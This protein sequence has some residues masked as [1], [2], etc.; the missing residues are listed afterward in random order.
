MNSN[1]H[2]YKQKLIA[3]TPLLLTSLVCVFFIV[4][5]HQLTK[6]KITENRQRAALT[7]INDVMPANYDNDIFNDNIKIDVPTYINNTN[8]I[9]AYRARLNNQ[10]VAVSLMPVMTKGY[11]GSISL[12]I[13]IAYDGTLNGVRIISHHETEGFGDKAHQDKSD[14]LLQFNNHNIETSAKDK[15]AIKKDDGE[16]DQLSGATITSRSIINIIY[17]TLEYYTENRDKFYL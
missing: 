14:W 8:S 7:I 13:G 3:I 2:S 17:K 11:N 6:E 1:S 12:I 15:W 10:P 4:L 9:T 5:I 16:F